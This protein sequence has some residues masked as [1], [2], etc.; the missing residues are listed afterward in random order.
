VGHLL[1]LGLGLQI[2]SG[3]QFRGHLRVIILTL[4]VRNCFNP[5]IDLSKVC[6]I[7]WCQG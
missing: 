5:S 2:W 6:T 4:K 3:L 1:G 7:G